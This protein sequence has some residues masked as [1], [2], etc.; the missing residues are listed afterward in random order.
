M[1]VYIIN[2]SPSIHQGD[3]HRFGRVTVIL[4]KESNK[5]FQELLDTG[6]ELTLIPGGPKHHYGLLI[7]IRFKEVINGV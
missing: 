3:L 4:E 6:F 7:S 5:N 2:L 1:I